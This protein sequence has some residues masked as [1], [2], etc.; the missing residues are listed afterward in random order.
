MMPDAHAVTDV[1][2]DVVRDRVGC[3]F[4]GKWRLEA[5]LGVGGT[6]SVYAAVDGGGRRAAIKIVHPDQGG[7]P[8]LGDRSRARARLVREAYVAN[9]LAP[10]GAVAV[11]ED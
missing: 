8:R 4:A 5:L 11:L 2:V 10:Y 9:E 1:D 7:Q 3:L 6:S